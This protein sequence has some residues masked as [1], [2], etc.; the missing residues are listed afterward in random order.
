MVKLPLLAIVV[1][2]LVRFA[3]T[4]AF[5]PSRV[6]LAECPPTP[7]PIVVMVTPG[8]FSVTAVPELTTC[9]LPVLSTPPD[10]LLLLTLF[11]VSVP[12]E[13]LSVPADRL[14][15]VQ[16]T[17]LVLAPADFWKV[18]P[19]WLVNVP[20]LP[21]GLELSL[22]SNRPPLWLVMF[23]VATPPKTRSLVPT[24]P[25]AMMPAL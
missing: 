5:D 23:V 25:T 3:E 9:Q 8:R 13:I 4:F 21:S 14:S 24:V 18:A 16:S 1:N 19:D 17:V 10:R 22:M 15:M 7:S 12:L 11:N 2:V 6:T 20:M